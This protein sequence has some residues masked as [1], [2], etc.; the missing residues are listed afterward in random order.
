M[1]F[2]PNEKQNFFSVSAGTGHHDYCAGIRKGLPS[3]Q[4]TI[5][6]AVNA[7]I[8]LHRGSSR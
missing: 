4:I 7:I 1:V 3:M 2:Y 5:L 8:A 6:E